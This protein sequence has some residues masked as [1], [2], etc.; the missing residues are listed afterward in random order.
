MYAAVMP[1]M[2]DALS[3]R[4]L[5]GYR[6]VTSTYFCT[7]CSLPLAH[8]E[9]FEKSTWPERSLDHHRYWAER[10]RDAPTEGEQV[11]IFKQHS[12][13]YTPLFHLPYFNPITFTIVDTMHNFFLGLLQCHCRKIWGM[14]LDTEDGDGKYLFHQRAPVQ[15]PQKGCE[16]PGGHWG[17]MTSMPLA[18]VVNESYSTF[19]L[20]WTSIGEGR[21]KI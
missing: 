10:W 6:S 11:E 14:D 13:R 15:P 18:N 17:S 16:P 1:I 20:S 9:N 21:K 19:V 12:L 8:F 2:C 3:A 5:C 7:Y 4:Q